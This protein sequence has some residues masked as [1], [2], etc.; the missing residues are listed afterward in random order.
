MAG[1]VGYMCSQPDCKEYTT[2]PNSSVEKNT[3]L[4]EAAHITAASPGG[5][6]DITKTLPHRSDDMLI[7]EFGCVTNTLD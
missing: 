3:I 5:G 1:N 2:G 6:Q 4:G 7:M